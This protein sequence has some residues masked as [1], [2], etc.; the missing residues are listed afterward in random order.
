MLPSPPLVVAPDLIGAQ[1]HRQ[2]NQER[3]EERE[4][5]GARPVV[6]PV[7]HWPNEGRKHQNT[8]QQTIDM[9]TLPR[10]PQHVRSDDSRVPA[11]WRKIQ[12][13]FH[14]VLSLLVVD[15]FAL[16]RQS[17][18]RLSVSL[19]PGLPETQAPALRFFAPLRLLAIPVETC[20]F[21][22]FPR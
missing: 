12:W 17:S 11:E 7:A 19:C 18:A 13:S 14:Y 9:E 10:E 5:V 6:S 2:G 21:S 3:N 1:R 22:I 15:R 20:N 16:P 4:E 8:T